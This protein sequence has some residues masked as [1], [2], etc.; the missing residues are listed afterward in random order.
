MNTKTKVKKTKNKSINYI[1]FIIFITILFIFYNKI[2]F[3]LQN[4]SHKIFISITTKLKYF[5]LL[6]SLLNFYDFISN[7]K[8]II[9][10]L[11]IFLYN[12]ENIYKIFILLIN[13]QISNSVSSLLKLFYREK[14]PFWNLIENKLNI[15]YVYQSGYGNPS[16]DVLIT[17]SF[18]LC[19][20]KLIF[21]SNNKFIKDH[22]NLDKKCFILMIIFILFNSFLNFISYSNSLDQIIFSLLLSVSIYVFIFYVFK[23][24]PNKLKKLKKIINYPIY[25]EFLIILSI[26]GVYLIIL[27][28]FQ[29]LNNEDDFKYE[30]ILNYLIN[31]DKKINKK[32]LINSLFFDALIN[33]SL[34]F[35]NFGMLIGLKI[36]YIKKFERNFNNWSLYNFEVEEEN[37][38][39]SESLISKLSVNKDI[40]WNHTNL[41]TRLIRFL[42]I[43][44]LILLSSIFYFYIK[45]DSNILLIII[46]KIGLTVN[47]IS[48][49]IFWFYKEI[50]KY[51]HLTNITLDTMMRESV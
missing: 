51:L 23:L 13:I 43:I 20:W 16:N 21:F 18:L 48:I 46:F 26:F 8:I 45:W 30:K 3:P 25:F 39:D 35:I 47:L 41:K 40:Q 44:I 14:R 38:D 42:I 9:I 4:K 19:F 7:S 12:Y 29:K 2:I 32:Y 17:T 37:N 31:D 11:L 27:I 28:T 50:L 1:L 10:F 6:E 36:E 24:N 15:N 33:F 5:N 22:P 34:I 49:G